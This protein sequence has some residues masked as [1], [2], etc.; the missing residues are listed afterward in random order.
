MKRSWFFTS[1]QVLFWGEGRPTPFS[2][3]HIVIAACLFHRMAATWLL[4]EAWVKTFLLSQFS[5]ITDHWSLWP[6]FAVLPQAFPANHISL[7]F[8][9]NSIIFFSFAILSSDFQA[10]RLM[11]PKNT[12]PVSFGSTWGSPIDFFSLTGFHQGSQI[13]GS[14]SGQH[15]HFMGNC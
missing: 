13:S 10:N 6:F 11:S 1:L 15:S 12:L 5:V 7:D 14:P 4:L 2:R 9:S 3:G 8:L